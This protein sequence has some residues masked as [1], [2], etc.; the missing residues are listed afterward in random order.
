MD[1]EVEEVM[2]DIASGRLA[3]RLKT[4]TT[5][6]LRGAW[7]GG[8]VGVGIA[9]FFGGGRIRMAAIGLVAGGGIGYLMKPGPKKGKE[10]IDEVDQY[11]G[12]RPGAKKVK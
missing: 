2:Q 4:N 11:L 5:Y 9:T 7:I 1:A 10:E 3:E 6:A 12:G 8:I